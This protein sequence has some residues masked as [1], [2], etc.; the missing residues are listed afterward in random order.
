MIKSYLDANVLL[1]ITLNKKN[2]C[3][4]YT[5][6]TKIFDEIK[7]GQ[8]HAVI[9]SLTLTEILFVLKTYFGKNES[10]LMGRSND[11]RIEYVNEQSKK[12]YDKL[13]SKL[14]QLPNVKFDDGNNMDSKKLFDNALEI[15]KNVKGKI[16][17]LN[18][19]QQCGADNVKNYKFKGAGVDD[20]L[21][22]L[23][24][25]NMGCDELITFDKDYDELDDFDEFKSLSIKVC[26]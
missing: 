5:L 3:G 26:K 14:L 2:E 8:R 18:Q 19:C 22:A 16:K 21:H 4:Q 12:M 10:E 20:I 6:A 11:E 25:K 23:M 9:S 13:T 17:S 7:S 15:M 24:A 1:G